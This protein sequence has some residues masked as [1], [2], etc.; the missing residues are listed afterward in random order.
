LSKLRRVFCAG[1]SMPHSW[2]RIPDEEPDPMGIGA[3]TGLLKNMAVDYDPYSAMP[4]MSSIPVNITF[5]D[6]AER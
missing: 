3:N 4:R 5:I 2:G 1:D 6:R